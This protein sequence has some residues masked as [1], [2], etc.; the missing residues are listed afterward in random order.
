M[1][2]MKKKHNYLP[3]KRNIMEYDFQQIKKQKN[4]VLI[5]NA[6]K[7]NISWK[8]RTDN[9]SGSKLRSTQMEATNAYPGQTR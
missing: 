4:S 6:G 1:R 2:K 8:Q 5:Y 7:T 9:K 3:R